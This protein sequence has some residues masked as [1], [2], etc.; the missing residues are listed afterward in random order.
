VA[1]GLLHHVFGRLPITDDLSQITHKTRPHFSIKRIKCLRVAVANALPKF[2]I[3]N[4]FPSPLCYS[5]LTPKKF[6]TNH[7]CAQCPR[8]MPRRNTE[9]KP[10]RSNFKV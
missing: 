9:P 8:A 6:I 3:L 10:K 5:G 2:V 7:N 4:Q 1:K